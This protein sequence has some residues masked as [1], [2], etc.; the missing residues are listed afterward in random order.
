ML[1]NDLQEQEGTLIK[2]GLTTEEEIADIMDG[3]QELIN[4]ESFF[5][6]YSQSCQVSGVK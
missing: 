6:A 3:L 4:D 5:I 1:I 2:H